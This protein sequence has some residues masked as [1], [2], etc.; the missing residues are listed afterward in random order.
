M[1]DACLLVSYGQYCDFGRGDE[2]FGLE[3][4]IWERWL[5]GAA[6]ER[7]SMTSIS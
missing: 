2:I 7:V 4:L 3:T 5:K 1:Y 6:E